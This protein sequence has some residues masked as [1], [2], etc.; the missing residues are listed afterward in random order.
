MK[1][2]TTSIFLAIAILSTAISQDGFAATK[3]VTCPKIIGDKISGRYAVGKT[4][5]ACFNTAA[6]AAKKGYANY[7]TSPTYYGTSQGSMTGYS[8]LTF[9]KSPYKVTFGQTGGSATITF[10]NTTTGET[11]NLGTVSGSTGAVVLYRKKGNVVVD[12]TTSSP[13]VVWFFLAE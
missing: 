12:V 6:E 11:T 8:T 7:L 5:Y 4:Y 1:F 3:K 10:R 2:V 9:N 13:S